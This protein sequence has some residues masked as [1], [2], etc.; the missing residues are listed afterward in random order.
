MRI[1]DLHEKEEKFI[2]VE[3][4]SNYNGW[5]T[6]GEEGILAGL[7]DDE[8][9]ELSEK[10]GDVLPSITGDLVSEDGKEGNMDTKTI[11]KVIK[12]VQKIVG[13]DVKVI[14]SEDEDSS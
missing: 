1:E 4:Q 13:S 2:K 11:A 8:L 12:A 6:L 5:S 14:I 10:I 9:D 3:W 7:S